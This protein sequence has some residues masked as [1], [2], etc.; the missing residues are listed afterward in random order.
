ME[1]KLVYDGGLKGI[2]RSKPSAFTSFDAFDEVRMAVLEAGG[3]YKLRKPLPITYTTASDSYGA[4]ENVVGLRPRGIAHIPSTVP[5]IIYWYGDKCFKVSPLSN[6]TDRVRFDK[7]TVST[8]WTGEGDPDGKKYKW[9]LF[10][11][12]SDNDH[13]FCCAGGALKW[14]KLSDFSTGT[15]GVVPTTGCNAICLNNRRLWVFAGDKAYYSAVDN[16]L[17]FTGDYLR[18]FENDETYEAKVYDNVIFVFTDK[19]IYY[20]TGNSTDDFKVKVMENTQVIDDC[21]FDVDSDGIYFMDK[22]AN[23]RLIGSNP[24]YNAASRS[25]VISQNLNLYDKFIANN[26]QYPTSINIARNQN[27]IYTNIGVSSDFTTA[28]GSIDATK[29]SDSDFLVSTVWNDYN[30]DWNIATTSIFRDTMTITAAGAYYNNA[31]PNNID[32]T[33]QLEIESG[34]DTLHAGIKNVLDMSTPN[35]GLY[36][37]A[38]AS[39]N[40]DFHY[41]DTSHTNL[42][43][44]AAN[45]TYY[46][47]IRVTNYNVTT[48]TGNVDVWYKTSDP[49]TSWGTASLSGTGVDLDYTWYLG[50]FSNGSL[51]TTSHIL[52]NLFYINGGQIGT[53]QLSDIYNLIY[54]IET[55]EWSEYSNFN[56]TI[57]QYPIEYMS[58]SKDRSLNSAQYLGCQYTTQVAL[59]TDGDNYIGV[60][61]QK[62]TVKDT[63]DMYLL[64]NPFN[65]G[66]PNVKI[67]RKFYIDYTPADAVVSLHMQNDTEFDDAVTSIMSVRSGW[68]TLPR[69]Y[70]GRQFKWGVTTKEETEFQLK[71]IGFEFDDLGPKAF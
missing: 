21:T 64:S 58:P 54:D 10:I 50:A 51:T 6:L 11:D 69:T 22:Y 23:I 3:L 17:S 29:D 57:K 41:S 48:K 18:L 43:T 60:F 66:T 28:T 26:L 12:A 67:L 5:S 2:Q 38:D 24:Y 53:I 52:K 62:G 30:D 33:F 39:N 42:A 56:S 40:I 20:I 34:K 19:K 46:F 25:T 15:V 14:I 45:G 9:E 61:N 63:S 36:I 16:G 68:N 8:L 37:V 7:S 31:V 65:I 1:K 49:G 27:K 44:G 4:V 59:Y 70:R 71:Q 13:L 47:R 55:K 32:L 35:K